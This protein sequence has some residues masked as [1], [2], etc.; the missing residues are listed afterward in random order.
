MAAR[1]STDALVR[2][3]L[4]R[5]PPAH[6]SARSRNL[7]GAATGFTCWNPM[8]APSRGIMFRGRD[9]ARLTRYRA[10]GVPRQDY[11]KWRSQ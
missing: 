1:H 3:S 6:R 11:A 10:S 5:V 2:G 4:V 8:A 9:R 7:S